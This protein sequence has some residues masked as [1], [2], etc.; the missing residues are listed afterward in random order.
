MR[1]LIFVL[2]GTFAWKQIAAQI[3]LKVVVK[4]GDAASNCDLFD[5]EPLWG[6]TVNR[7]PLTLFRSSSYQ[8]CNLYKDHRTPRLL[9]KSSHFCSNQ[10]EQ[11]EVCL[12]IGDDDSSGYTCLFADGAKDHS[13]L[14]CSHVK[15]AETK[16]PRCKAGN[17]NLKYSKQI[18]ISGHSG[19]RGH[20]FYEIQ[21]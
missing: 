16:I 6:I 17:C 15:C 14:G 9:Y 18:S 7:G 2:I 1:I 21:R 12:H 11:V 8:F 13:D 10:A 3:H 4:S 19:M 5:D 20:V